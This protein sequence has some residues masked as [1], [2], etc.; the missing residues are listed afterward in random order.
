MKKKYHENI[1]KDLHYNSRL[2]TALRS[3]IP[4]ATAVCIFCGKDTIDAYKIKTI[5]G[6]WKEV[7]QTALNS[8]QTPPNHP[9]N[10]IIHTTNSNNTSVTQLTTSK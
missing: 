6:D 7:A 3:L 9:I 4:A 10:V 1:M 2:S 5:S 8:G